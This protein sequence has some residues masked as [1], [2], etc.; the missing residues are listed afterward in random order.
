[1]IFSSITFSSLDCFICNCNMNAIFLQ[2]WCRAATDGW[3]G[4]ACVWCVC[5]AVI[6]HS[7]NSGIR[8]LDVRWGFSIN[9]FRTHSTALYPAAEFMKHP[10]TWGTYRRVGLLVRTWENVVAYFKVLGDSERSRKSVTVI[11]VSGRIRIGGRS[12]LSLCGVDLFYF[13]KISDRQSRTLDKGRSFSTW[14][15]TRD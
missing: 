7:N 2:S 5:C 12:R 11:G 13:A 4:A 10:L 14:S 1:M 8:H 6:G 15:W 9:W 3:T